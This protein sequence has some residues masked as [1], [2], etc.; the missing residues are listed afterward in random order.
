MSGFI[1]K[2]Y[3]RFTFNQTRSSSGPNL[4]RENKLAKLKEIRCK[5]M[6]DQSKGIQITRPNE[7][8]TMATKVKIEEQLMHH[9]EKVDMLESKWDN[10]F[11][12]VLKTLDHILIN[13]NY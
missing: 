12:E 6:N 7:I 3:L 9:L 10:Q 2:G 8:N 1:K 5:N 11:N 13:A 4:S